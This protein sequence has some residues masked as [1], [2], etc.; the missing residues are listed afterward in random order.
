MGFIC[1]LHNL[2]WNYQYWLTVMTCFLCA[3]HVT[4]HTPYNSPKRWAW[5]SLHD[6]LAQE[7]EAHGS[8]PP[9]H[10]CEAVGCPQDSDPRA[11]K[12]RPSRED[13]TQASDGQEESGNE[14]SAERF[15]YSL[16]FLSWGGSEHCGQCSVWS[17]LFPHLWNRVG[18]ILWPGCHGTWWALCKA[19]IVGLYRPFAFNLRHDTITNFY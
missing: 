14:C 1:L 19:V 16:Q 6:T 11:L 10:G 4:K 12:G 18:I 3:K 8:A 7:S 2:A 15:G 13:K 9:W 5:G 17:P